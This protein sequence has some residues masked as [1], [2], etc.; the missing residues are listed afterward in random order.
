VLVQF[1]KP[2]GRKTRHLFVGFGWIPFAPIE[3]RQQEPEDSDS[4][5]RIAGG[6]VPNFVCVCQNAADPEP[7][8]AGVIAKNR[9]P[10]FIQKTEHRSPILELFS[11]NF[12]RVSDSDRSMWQGSII[13]GFLSAASLEYFNERLT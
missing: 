3:N 8:Y 5:H 13:G 2:L 11:I 10:W 6:N 7:L 1:V 12:A 4:V 9:Y